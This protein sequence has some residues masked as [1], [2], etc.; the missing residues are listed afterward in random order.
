M[1]T[2]DDGPLR[3]A[4]AELLE[5]AAEQVYEVRAAL[6]LVDQRRGTVVVQLSVGPSTVATAIEY[7]PEHRPLAAIHLL[8]L[9]DE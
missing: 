4:A 6:A 7:R 9:A 2:L 1:P 8:T 5:Q 3:L